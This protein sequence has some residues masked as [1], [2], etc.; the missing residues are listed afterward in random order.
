MSILFSY[1]H[2]DDSHDFY[3]SNSSYRRFVYT[4]CK[5]FPVPAKHLV[6][7]RRYYQWNGVFFSSEFERQPK[8][9][10]AQLE[11]LIKV[12][13]LIASGAIDLISPDEEP[14]VPGYREFYSKFN[15]CLIGIRRLLH[16]EGSV[17]GAGD[18]ANESA[19]P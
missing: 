3:L 6:L 9:V 1:S 4:L 14:V 19:E 15:T 16:Q 8:L 10:L 13:D 7:Y 18:L 12:T 2:S 5:T 17:A 11:E